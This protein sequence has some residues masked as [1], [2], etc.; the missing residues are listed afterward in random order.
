[1]RQVFE[2]PIGTEHLCD[3]CLVDI[4]PRLGDRLPCPFGRIVPQPAVDADYFDQ[5]NEHLYS[6]SLCDAPG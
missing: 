3:R 6:A 5:R 1:M 2:R 4:I